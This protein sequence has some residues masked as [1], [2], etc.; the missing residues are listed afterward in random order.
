MS[1]CKDCK[2]SLGEDFKKV[3]GGH[4]CD[5]CYYKRMGEEFDKPPPCAPRKRGIKGISK[6]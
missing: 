5:D 2:N 1:K 6:L 4:V 3:K